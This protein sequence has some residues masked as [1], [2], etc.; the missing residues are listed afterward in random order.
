MS[1][2]APAPQA[3]MGEPI[4]R[5][6]AFAKV[7]GRA[8]YASDVPH[9]RPAHAFLLLSDIGRGSITAIDDAAA[10]AVPGVLDIMTH[11]NRPALAK[12]QGMQIT[13]TLPLGGPEI[14]HDGQIIGL[15]TAE[16]YEAAREAAH[17]VI[18]RYDAQ[19]PASVFDAPGVEDQKTQEATKGTFMPKEDPHLGD[20]AAALAAAA[21]T[22]NAHYATPTQH[23]NSM[24]LFSTTAAWNG[25]ELTVDEP[26][27]FVF[28][29]RAGVANQLG[30]AAEKVHIRSEY[31]GGAFGGKASLTHRTALV[32]LAAKKLGRPV[33]LVATRDAGF[34]ISGH[35]QETRHHI[36]M[37]ADRAG[38]ITALHHDIWELTSRTDAYCNGGVE[39]GAAMYAFPAVQS[40]GH[41]IRA[42]RNT[43]T[44]MRSPP[45]LPVMFALESAMDEMA[46]TV[47]M[48]PVEFRRVN[49]TD[50]DWLTGKPYSSRSLM[51]CYDEAARAFGW[52]KR[53]ARPGAMRDGDWLIGYGCATAC[54]PTQM[55]S[56]V[57][58][59]TLFADGRARVDC[60][61]HDVGQGVKTVISQFAAEFL[62]LPDGMVDV[63]IG[64]STLPPGPLAGGSISTAS[65]GSAVKLACE[66][67]LARL[68]NTPA[69]STE[70][71]R[72]AFTRLGIAEIAETGEYVAEG[73]KP[74][75][76]AGLYK[77]FPAFS[78]SAQQARTQYAFGAEFVEVRVHA[79]TREVRVPRIVGAFAAGRIVNPRTA[80]SQLM[81][82]MIWG[83]SSALHEATE[84]DPRRAAYMNNNLAEYLVP[85]NA[86]IGAVDVILVPEVDD[87]VNPVGVKG[88]GEL[89]NVGTA[90]A[91]AN[92]VYQATG[93]RVRELPIRIE[94]LMTV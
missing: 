30:I 81:G 67:I 91:V 80:H 35:R 6:D 75:Q 94:G 24:E 59:V 82:G 17:R 86:D 79:R 74:A 34:T 50:K 28:G 64:N 46:E 22:I 78:A 25:D 45:E 29:L 77:G 84:I 53:G 63:H 4:A 55:G 11:L 16:T 27:Q 47:G 76:I 14:H 12:N 21:H 18:L 8:N 31:L 5:V 39:S 48:D 58:R 62:G 72:A 87:Q 7:T 54:Y 88:L 73:N 70:Q 40:T 66:K 1:A 92:A 15:V 38:R 60:A 71:R 37:G 49:D 13:S 10:R 32:A 43:P 20:A 68:G 83:I 56:C 9:A 61:A 23:H 65:A 93:K 69:T 19:T 57:A 3:N 52:S 44:F 90:A 41:L 2:A 33:K 51:K 26:S 42:D 85:V 89:G 36:R